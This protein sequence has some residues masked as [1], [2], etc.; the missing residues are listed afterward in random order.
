MRWFRMIFQE[1][2]SIYHYL[3]IIQ[4][5]Y[6]PRRYDDLDR[7]FRS[8]IH[9]YVSDILYISSNF[10]SH[11]HQIFSIN[12]HRFCNI[13]QYSFIIN[14]L[15]SSNSPNCKTHKTYNRTNER[16]SPFHQAAHISSVLHASWQSST[17]CGHSLGS[18]VSE[19]LPPQTHKTMI[20]KSFHDLV[21]ESSA[22][23]RVI[24]Q[25][26]VSVAA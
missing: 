10:H 4:R 3:C 23:E 19:S 22:R 15:A 11:L 21:E 2:L 8:K 26:Y 5:L 6:V 18:F 17:T 24:I 13:L 20:V 9:L 14:T 25:M 16:S 1:L 7:L 12:L